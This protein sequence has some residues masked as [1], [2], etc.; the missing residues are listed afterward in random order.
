M[1]MAVTVFNKNHLCVS[2][3]VENLK[4]IVFSQQCNISE[5]LQ[6]SGLL[7]AWNAYTKDETV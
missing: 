3:N 2:F 5:K 6:N 4:H 1:V 7:K